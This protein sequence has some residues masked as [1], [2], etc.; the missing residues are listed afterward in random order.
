MLIHCQ[1]TL[2]S[3]RVLYHGTDHPAPKRVPLRAG[4]LSLFYEEG[5]LRY[6]KWGEHEVI[7]RVHVTVRDSI[8]NTL[9]SRL[10]NIELQ[11][12]E[13]SFRITYDAEN[14]E[15]VIDFFWHAEITGGPSGTITFRMK[16]TARSNFR[17]S[18]I[19]FCVLHPMHE[20]AGAKCVVRHGDDSLLKSTFP[21]T[22]LPHA[23]FS[24]M[25]SI[26]HEVTPGMWAKVQFE[27]DLFEMEDQRNWTDASFKTYCTPLRLPYPVEIEAGTQI[28]QS[29]TLNLLP[30]NQLLEKERDLAGNGQLE[31]GELQKNG[32][33][34]KNGRPSKNH[35]LKPHLPVSKHQSQRSIA[36]AIDSFSKSRKVASIGLGVASH[37]QPLTDREL[38]RLDRLRLAHL[39]VDLQLS[40]TNWRAVLERAASETNSL[41]IGLEVALFLSDEAKLEL[42]QLL[43]A[44]DDMARSST[45]PKI[46]RWLVFHAEQ[47]STEERWVAI[48]RQSLATYDNSIPVGSGTN[49]YFTQLNRGHPPLSVVDTVCYSIN[50]QAHA[51][52]LCSLVETLEAQG[53]TVENARRLAGRSPLAV[54]PITLRPR[55]NPKL[56][57]DPKVAPEKLPHSVDPRQA[58]LFGAAWT[59]GSLKYLNESGVESLTYYE[60]TGWRGVVETEAGSPLPEKFRSLP[61]TVFPLYHVLADFGDFADGR[62]LPCRSC[63][64]L[65][66]EAM[67]LTREGLQEKT[68]RM[69]LGNMTDEPQKVVVEVPA[70]RAELKMLDETNVLE[71]IETCET[72]RD[73]K[74]QIIEVTNG[75]I[76]LELLPFAVA[77]LD[78]S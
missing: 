54:T 4:P 41:G 29:I 19:G 3:K 71:A 70:P 14:V 1:Q 78:W 44:L 17:R 53:I 63:D 20:C 61:G 13:D 48:A 37:G 26:A 49:L 68:T 67:V 40:Q 38:D 11:V 58:S 2:M 57:A 25:K 27:G 21:Q 73:K 59:L 45:E 18:R 5:D 43:A 35:A 62:I 46:V 66:V 65:R 12:E 10:T 60:T 31:N 47:D 50:P 23:P 76:D 72:F 69:M 15:G 6:I 8:W 39:R 32:L 64:P 55:F 30:E 28:E 34:E 77:R 52:D 56:K 74:G 51:F 9:G 7:R 33:R 42:S 16:G 24:E 75:K 36:I 22:L